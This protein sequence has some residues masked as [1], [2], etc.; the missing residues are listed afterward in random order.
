MI[1]RNG[2]TDITGNT[3]LDNATIDYVKID[4]PYIGHIDETDLV[5]FSN[6]FIHRRWRGIRYNA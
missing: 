4:G 2:D 3:T 5:T 1:D 6:G